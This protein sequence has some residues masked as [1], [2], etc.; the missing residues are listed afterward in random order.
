MVFARGGSQ[1]SGN[2]VYKAA[3]ITNSLSNESQAFSWKEFQRMAP[4][5]GFEM[6]VFAGE[7]EPQVEV[8]G[9]DQAIAEKYD[10]IFIC[11]SNIESI[12]PAITRAKQAGVIVGMFS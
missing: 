12:V 8:A 11:P 3:F 7:F 2:R 10:A 6:R 1:A 5:Y 4:Q 9:I